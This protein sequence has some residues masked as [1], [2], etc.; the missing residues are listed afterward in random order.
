[1]MTIRRA[2]AQDAVLI[3]ELAEATWWPTYEP[4]VGAEQVRYMLDAFYGTEVI[5]D[6]ISSGSQTY[7]LLYDGDTPKGFAAYSPRLEDPAIYKLHKLYCLPSEQG[8]GLGRQLVEAVE[9]AVLVGGSHI[10]DLNVN[11]YNK[12]KTFYEK[13]GFSVIYDEDIKIGN[14]YEMND[15]VMRKDLSGDH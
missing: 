13:L 15:H 5:T 10:L 1:M 8:K 11:R 6:Q 4:I 12:A 3:Q 14:G 7:I 9:K 2:T